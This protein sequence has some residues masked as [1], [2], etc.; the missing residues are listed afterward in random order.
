MRLVCGLGNPGAVFANTRH[1]AG[2]MVLD[3]L[4]AKHSLVWGRAKDG[5][6]L[7]KHSRDVLLA[8]PDAFMNVSGPP[9][10]ALLRYYKVFRFCVF[11]SFVSL[12][13]NR[14]SW[15]TFCLCAT[16]CLWSL[17]LSVSLEEEVTLVKM[18]FGR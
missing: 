13:G 3:R 12:P 4:A 17:A 5:V 9:V 18:G 10:G 15:R 8:K 11:V 14:L 1:N 16:A 2:F 7:A 6:V